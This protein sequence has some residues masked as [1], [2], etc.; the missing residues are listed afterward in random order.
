MTDAAEGYPELHQGRFQ[1]HLL[2]HGLSYDLERPLLHC[3]DGRIITAGEF[4]DLTS[5][6][7][8]AFAKAG[9]VKGDR[10]AI[11]SGNRPEVLCVT[12]ACL[13]GQFVL[14][15]LHPAGSQD[16]LLFV[17]ADS[18]SRAL[19]FDPVKYSERA[20]SVQERA[21]GCLL[22]ALGA[23][24]IGADLC[25]LAA[26]IRPDRLIAPAVAPN[27]PYRLSYSGGTTGKPKAVV[28]THRTGAA[29]LTIQ[30]AEWEW[31]SGI[32]QL[33]CAPLSHAG[34]AMFL[35]T[36]LRGGSM[37]ILAGFDPVTV[38]S[39]IQKHRINCVLLVPTMIYALLS[40]PR[41]D[42]F[43][44]SSLETIFYGASSMSPTR[45]REGILKFGPVFFQ[46]YGQVEAP[47][48]ITVM[49]R[50]D[51]DVDDP[52]RLAS[53]GRPVPWIDVALLDDDL[54]EVPVGEPGE[55]CVRGPLVMAE[56]F[57]RPDL[58]AAALAGGWL[59]TGDVAV[60]R[61]D[62]FLRIVDRKKDM[63][64][65]GGFNVY[66]REI[67]DVLSSHPAV[68]TCA[69]IG[70]PDEHWGEAVKAVVVLRPGALVSA[71]ELRALVRERK[72]SIQA[73]KTVD[74][75]SAIPLT[76]VGKPDKKQLRSQAA[77]PAGGGAGTHA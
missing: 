41:L 74:F 60:R 31:P 7:V 66:P 15:P 14:V 30:L 67:E 56:Y 54:R 1:P 32:R 12:A 38:M 25:A 58:T 52:D 71:D 49:K 11:L 36:L 42:E 33:V 26:A 16:D 68:S 57:N 24:G 61:P 48:T 4:R 64:V 53:C 3:E 59:H 21:P 72:G 69:V 40:H 22:F 10:I 27:E 70:V 50:G 76:P 63:I 13:I 2:V 45:L 29:V 23:A 44:L 28:G 75:V 46:F 39:A 55:I 65:T 34:A 20:A 18:A 35:P 5:Q 37:V 19:V 8:Q 6:Y 43:D 62:G 77:R 17:I 9:M 47:M 73:P 51:H